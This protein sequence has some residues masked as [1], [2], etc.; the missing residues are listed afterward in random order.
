MTELIELFLTGPSPGTNEPNPVANSQNFAT[1]FTKFVEK[2]SMLKP[3]TNSNFFTMFFVSSLLTL[4]YSQLLD[5]NFILHVHFKIDADNLIKIVYPRLVDQNIIM[6][7]R[8]VLFGSNVVINSQQ[9]SAAT[10]ELISSP[11]HNSMWSSPL[12]NSKLAVITLS[13]FNRLYEDDSI[14]ASLLNINQPLLPKLVSN[15]DYLLGSL[16]NENLE[17]FLFWEVQSIFR[18]LGSRDFNIVSNYMLGQMLSLQYIEIDDRYLF[19]YNDHTLRNNVRTFVFT[20]DDVAFAVNII[21]DKSVALTT[22]KL[23][24][25]KNR[26]LLS[27]DE[28]SK[29]A[30]SSD[31]WKHKM[32]HLNIDVKTGKICISKKGGEGQIHKNTGVVKKMGRFTPKKFILSAGHVTANLEIS[33]LV[34]PL[35]SYLTTQDELI[36]LLAGLF[37]K[38]YACVSTTG[39]DRR[40]ML[41]LFNI[42]SNT[43]VDHQKVGNEMQNQH[44]ENLPTV[45]SSSI[46]T[47]NGACAGN[48][49]R[50]HSTP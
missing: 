21:K 13:N 6:E 16:T 48:G 37:S 22:I 42:D 47:L 2:N 8:T 18:H 50:F 46:E 19:I 3:A 1:E 30:V 15:M 12:T 26:R 34:T 23:W 7:F 10:V 17:S 4:P 39:S 5:R 27:Y 41:F 33:K 11:I 28:S 44:S 38:E 45:A 25:S 29:F 14:G 31:V 43:V 20:T 9:H 40:R 35:Y 24:E 36:A 49:Y 32:I